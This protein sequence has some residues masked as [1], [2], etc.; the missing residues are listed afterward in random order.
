MRKFPK[1]LK[2]M[3]EFYGMNFFDLGTLMAMLYLSMVFNLNALI[4][5]A[6]CGFAVITMKV[7][8]AN[9][10]FKGWLL[11]RTKEIY[12]KDLERGDS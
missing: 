12:L 10:D 2:A 1:F 8:R 3:P 11:P 7:L 5:V 4:S 9:F 6:L